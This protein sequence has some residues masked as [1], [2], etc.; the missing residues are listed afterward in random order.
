MRHFTNYRLFYEVIHKEWSIIKITVLLILWKEKRV[1]LIKYKLNHNTCNRGVR[2]DTKSNS[3][4]EYAI[5]HIGLD[6]Y[7]MKQK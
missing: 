4:N 5:V 2:H 6:I 7:M 1:E 3:I